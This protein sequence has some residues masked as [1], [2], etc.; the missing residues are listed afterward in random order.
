MINATVSNLNPIGSTSTTAPTSISWTSSSIT[1]PITASRVQT[2][3]QSTVSST[4]LS[5]YAAILNSQVSNTIAQQPTPVQTVFNQLQQ[6]PNATTILNVA[7]ANT[8]L[9][10]C[11]TSTACNACSSSLIADLTSAG[12]NATNA[13][14]LT[15]NLILA[16]NADIATWPTTINTLN[17]TLQQ[18]AQATQ[19]QQNQ[20]QATPKLFTVNSPPFYIGRTRTL[21]DQLLAVSSGN[22]RAF[23]NALTSSVTNF[24]NIRQVWNLVPTFAGSVPTG[25]RRR[26]STPLSPTAIQVTFTY[27]I[28]CLPADTA[29]QSTLLTSAALYS[30]LSSALNNGFGVYALAP[31]QCQLSGYTQWSA[32]CLRNVAFDACV[33]NFAISGNNAASQ[34]VGAQAVYNITSC[35]FQPSFP[36]GTCLDPFNVIQS[37]ALADAQTYVIGMDCTSI[38]NTLPPTTASTTT[39]AAT[40]VGAAASSGGGGGVG[41]G[42]VAGAAGGGIAVIIIIIAV[43]MYFRKQKTAPK[44]KVQCLLCSVL[45]LERLPTTAPLLPLRIPCTTTLR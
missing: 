31:L 3:A 44:S 12:V 2:V 6:T 35:G 7:N 27:N 42:M 29:C 32:T 5:L 23:A 17:T 45:I 39:A 19:T 9:S 43:A 41:L 13:A 14:T 8:C 30:S 16:K 21:A 26:R 4:L 18:A 40:T 33:A 10:T 11:A 37:S 20:N 38:N 34:Q 22:S 36:N 15:N 25:F 28:S 1:I 24:Q